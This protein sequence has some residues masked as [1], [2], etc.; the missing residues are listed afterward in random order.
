[1]EWRET[2]K[3]EALKSVIDWYLR[4]HPEDQHYVEDLIDRLNDKIAEI[5]DKKIPSQESLVCINNEFGKQYSFK[6]LNGMTPLG[7][8]IVQR[9]SSCG[10]NVYDS[11][12]EKYHGKPF[13]T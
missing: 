7:G 8:D 4:Q 9:C 5:E 2:M 13:L 10:M 11:E 3:H 6:Y 1:M 12:W